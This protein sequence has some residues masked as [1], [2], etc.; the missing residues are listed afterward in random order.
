ML[1]S[2]AGGAFAIKEEI[3]IPDGDIEIGV[4]PIV[5]G[6]TTE[7]L[8]NLAGVV[9][10]DPKFTYNPST[11]ILDV[12]N[13]IKVHAGDTAV[14]TLGTFS[15]NLY[16]TGG[17]SKAYGIMAGV[18]AAGDS[19]IQVQRSDASATAYA[20][21]LQPS[22]NFVSVGRTTAGTAMFEVLQRVS[23]SGTPAALLIT[24]AAHTSLTAST[25]IPDIRLNLARSVQFATGAKT[26]QRAMQI[27]A[28]TYTAVGATTITAAFT[29]DVDGAPIAGTNVTITGRSGIRSLGG[30][31][32][33]GDTNDNFGFNSSVSGSGCLALGSGAAVSSSN[34][35]AIGCLT[36]SAGG[37]VIGGGS[38]ESS[39]LVGSFVVGGSFN[40]IT[41]CYFGKGVV[42]TTPGAV[43]LQSTGE[44]GTDQAGVAFNLAG[45][46]ATGNALGGNVN[47]Q[48]STAGASG[49]TLQTLAT[50][51]T[52]G[53]L[54]GMQMSSRLQRKQGADVASAT[55]LAVGTD[56]DT[57]ELT[58]TTKVDLISNVNFQEGAEIT[59]IANESVVIDHG[60]A[61]SGTN[62]QI[63]LA[64]AVDYS[65]TAGDTL[66]LQLSSTTAEG[67]AWRELGR[68]VI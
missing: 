29:L 19:W 63:R 68:A 65:M 15:G 7:I 22:G 62:V 47:I 30:F 40:I 27:N 18:T 64:G 31:T 5:G 45:G 2:W 37:I 52:F 61:T 28:P 51:A 14:P 3:I 34:G 33:T 48:T 24:G 32:S 10:S 12:A 41:D 42:S 17:A 25:D 56:G 6:A 60:T 20:L 8:Y 11:D 49:A 9:S 44:L 46:K 35:I 16:L 21:M 55:N 1:E 4:T 13:A 53:S 38:Q 39:V 66:T 50:R 26:L 59:L 67:Q 57:F 23:T 54:I 36:P 43:T 58:G